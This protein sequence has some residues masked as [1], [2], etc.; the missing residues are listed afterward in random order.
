MYETSWSL[1]W[2]SESIEM[3][4]NDTH[5]RNCFQ[6]SSVSE[7]KVGSSRLPFGWMDRFHMHYVWWMNIEYQWNE[8]L[9]I[10]GEKHACLLITNS[11]WSTIGLNHNF[12]DKKLMYNSVSWGIAIS[13]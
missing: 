9:N 12:H 4:L 6:Q 1:G 13:I 11:I 7:V 8:N 10:Q 5:Q 3:V 2:V